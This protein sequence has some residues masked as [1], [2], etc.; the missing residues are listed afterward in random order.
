M[1]T[2]QQSGCV[3]TGSSEQSECSASEQANA[4]FQEHHHIK[5]VGR[6]TLDATP[7]PTVF[8]ERLQEQGVLGVGPPLALLGDRV[9]LPS[10]R[11]KS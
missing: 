4:G 10:L 2:T 5:Q 3:G 9:G 8:A 6:L 11:Q 7:R 1:A